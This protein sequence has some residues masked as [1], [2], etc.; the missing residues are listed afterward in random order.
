MHYI[1]HVQYRVMKS[2]RILI[3]LFAT[4]FQKS[5][6]ILNPLYNLSIKTLLE[7]YRKIQ[8]VLG[9]QVIKTCMVFVLGFPIAF[10]KNEK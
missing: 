10:L 7:M 3:S 1:I 9:V 4:Y 5:R 2:L 6:G 8:T